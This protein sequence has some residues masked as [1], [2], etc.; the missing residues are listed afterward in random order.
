M[1]F[2]KLLVV[3]YQNVLKQALGSNEKL[4]IHEVDF[5]L[6]IGDVILLCSDG[7]YNEVSDEYIKKKMQDGISAESLV[8]EVLLLNPKDNVSAIV[9]NLI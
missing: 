5:Q 1:R 9:I 3:I 7:L 8:S 6:R 2:K 4:K